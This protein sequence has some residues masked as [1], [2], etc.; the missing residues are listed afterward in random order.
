MKISLSM[1]G[2]LTFPDVLVE[3]TTNDGNAQVTW[4]DVATTKARIKVEAVDN[5]FFD[6]NDAD[7]T[8]LSDNDGSTPGPDADHRPDHPPDH[9]A[10]PTPPRPD[11]DADADHPAGRQGPAADLD[12]DGQAGRGRRPA[13]S[14][15]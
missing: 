11:A 15:G 2:G 1:D 14:C 9:P 5:Y 10:D 13:S 6:V 12:E 4:P 8:I 7:I 3:S